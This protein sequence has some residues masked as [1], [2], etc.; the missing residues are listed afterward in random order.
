LTVSQCEPLYHDQIAV[1]HGGIM[2]QL[3]MANKWLQ[4]S[5]FTFP[6]LAVTATAWL[7]SH[8]LLFAGFWGW[9][10]FLLLS[11]LTTIVGYAF[12]KTI[13]FN[14]SNSGLAPLEDVQMPGAKKMGA[15]VYLGLGKLALLFSIILFCIGALAAGSK[16]ADYSVL[17]AALGWLIVGFPSARFVRKL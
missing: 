3:L 2:Q 12:I 8:G 1:A 7:F 5:P 4:D 10:A 15:A 11:V 16:S 9:V 13:P 17:F 14:A 6:I